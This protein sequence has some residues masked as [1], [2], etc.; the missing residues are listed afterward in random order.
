MQVLDE[1]GRNYAGQARLHGLDVVTPV[2]TLPKG[3]YTVRWHAL[4][5]DSHVVSGVWTFGVRVKA[6][7][8]ME[9]YGAVGP[10]RT[11]HLVR[12]GYFVALALVDR[13]AR[14]SG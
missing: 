13:L 5:A 12:W 4:S 11:E 10:T 8:P 1:N 9:A 14:A 3:A 7:P 6:P 2:R